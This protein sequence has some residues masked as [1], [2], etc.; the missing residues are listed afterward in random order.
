MILSDR[1]RFVFVHVPK[2]AGTSVRAAVLPYHDADERFLKT[3]E[4]HPELGEID[5]RHLPLHL[6]RDLDPE[7]FEKLKIYD[8]YAL[9]RDPFQRFRSAMAQRAKMYLGREFAQLG[10]KE[11]RS[12][13]R[14]VQEYLL[15]EPRVIAP[16][17]IHFARQSD[18]VQIGDQRLVFNLFPVERLDLF[19]QALARHIGTATLQLGHANKTKVFRHPHLKHVA[20]TSS[21]LARRML[22]GPVHETLRRSAR[23][24]LM[25]PVSTAGLP[26][27]DEAEMRDFIAGYYSADI[28]LYKEVQAR[29]AADVRDR[30]MPVRT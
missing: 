1:H 9:L 20:R 15:S 27:F 14:R 7:A 19:A 26:V 30:Q 21:V 25:K 2:C 17:F 8:S 12:E 16:E 22:P 13:L 10:G 24:L 3:V 6:L 4:R 5:F 23:R 28:A 18:F 11:L 29:M